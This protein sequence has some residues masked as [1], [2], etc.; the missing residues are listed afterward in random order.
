MTTNRL[1]QS[2]SPYL[3][4]HSSNPVDWFPWGTEA[5]QIAQE[6]NKLVLV[7]IGYSTCHWCHVMA[8]EVFEDPTAAAFQNRSYVS[9]KV[10]REERPDIDQIYMEACRMLTGQGGWPLNVLCLPDGRPVHAATYLP[11]ESW[12]HLLGQLQMMWLESP[13]RVIQQ[14]TLLAESLAASALPDFAQAPEST[15][16]PLTRSTENIL[17]EAWSRVAPGTDELYGGSSHTPKFPLPAQLAAFAEISKLLPPDE[18]PSGAWKG[19]LRTYVENTLAN[20]ALGGIS[21]QIGGGFYRYSTDAQWHIP[22][23]EKMLYDNAQMLSLYAQAMRISPHPL[24]KRTLRL[25]LE[26]L[27]REMKTPEGLWYSALNADSE[28]EEGKAYLWNQGQVFEALQESPLIEDILATFDITNQGNWESGQSH[29][30]IPERIWKKADLYD[31]TANLEMLEPARLLLFKTRSLRIQPSR[32]DKILLE[33]NALT[34]KGLL[35]AGRALVQP[36][37]LSDG[38]QTLD[39]IYTHLRTPTGTFLRSICNGIPGPHAFLPDLAA[40]F[41][42]DLA[43]YEVTQAPLWLERAQE[44]ATLLLTHHLD[45]AS[46]FFRMSSVHGETLFAHRIDLQDDV[47]PC[48]NSQIALCLRT[49]GI[50]TDNPVFVEHATKMVNTLREITLLE[51]SYHAHWLRAFVHQ[52]SPQVTVR[53]AGPDAQRWAREVWMLFPLA[54]IAGNELAGMDLQETTAEV[55]LGD[56]CLASVHD[57]KGLLNSVAGI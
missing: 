7:S 34:A 20:L 21:D 39:A 25:T 8:H 12:I 42:A 28:G 13:E 41:A 17:R 23:F 50:L 11:K 52:A 29:I 2:S 46:P 19:K 47:I 24:W 31:V 1:A 54:I 10:D 16:E 38:L 32:D 15:P 33:W 56:R 14:A 36:R 49:L 18:N 48:A 4:Q 35:D 3:L 57:L 55:C 22:H 40:L 9:I 5:F 45:S 51:P 37:T 6:S 30:R 44:V 53:I 27:N 26:W 43:A